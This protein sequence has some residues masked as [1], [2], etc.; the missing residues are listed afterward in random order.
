MTSLSPILDALEAELRGRATVGTGGV[1][2][3]EEDD[4]FNDWALRIHEAQCRT[5]PPLARFWEG[6]GASSP[7][8]W[9]EISPV[10]AQAFK[11]MP[12]GPHEAE[13]VFRTSGTTGGGERRGEH[14]IGRL[15]LYRAAARG[16]YRAALL[17]QGTSLRMM[18]LVTHPEADPNSSLACMAGFIA[19]EAEVEE[20]AWCFR[21]TAGVLVEECRPWLLRAC[22][23]RTPVLILST[24]FALAQ[25][26]EALAERPI[27]LP[28][29]STLMETGGF[30]GRAVALGRRAL[31]EQVESTLGIGEPHIV[32]EYGM[33]ELLSQ[34]Y[35]GRA[36]F[37]GPVAE[38]RHRFPPWV[39][40]RVLDPVSLEPVDPDTRG[41]LAHFDLANAASVCHVLTEDLGAMDEGGGLRLL[42][43][44]EG[45]EARGCSLMAESFVRSMEGRR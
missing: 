17:P 22:E 40:T 30:K 9:T 4:V 38:R 6:R 29:G 3:F 2:P 5:Y 7:G 33:T 31:Y 36:G 16:S 34:A 42:G 15:S 27:S 20:A 44:A 26:L 21:P 28:A 24:A 32:G 14:R 23:D 41:V 43:R 8:H 35:D 19:L 10:P 13:A 18:S 25:L 1:D 37:A 11:S 12:L 45:S 39:R